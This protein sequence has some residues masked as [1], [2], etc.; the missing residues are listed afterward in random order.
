MAV[1]TAYIYNSHNLFFNIGQPVTD[2]SGDV[3]MKN[4]TATSLNSQ[5]APTSS[6]QRSSGRR[7]GAAVENQPNLRRTTRQTA[8]GT[9]SRK[10]IAPLTKV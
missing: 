7:G 5:Y 2:S 8:A 1:G 9:P 3:E 10:S 6:P 4:G